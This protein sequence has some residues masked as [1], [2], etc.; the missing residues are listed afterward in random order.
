MVLFFKYVC[1]LPFVDDRS[2]IL[3]NCFQVGR[4]TNDRT[5]QRGNAYLQKGRW[6]E[7]YIAKQHRVE[8]AVS[9]VLPKL[10]QLS[11]EEPFMKKTCCVE[12]TAVNQ[13]NLL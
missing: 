1:V 10:S 13:E 2:D 11:N 3:D 4:E 9:E 12:L 5:K 8:P 6:R 7:R